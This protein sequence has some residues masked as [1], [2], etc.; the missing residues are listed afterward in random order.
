LVDN[1]NEKLEKKQKKQKEVLNF[2]Y[3]IWFDRIPQDITD[4]VIRSINSNSELK[5][6]Y[7]LQ[8]DIDLENASLGFESLLWDESLSQEQ[9]LS[10]IKLFNKMITWDEKYPVFID[11]AWILFFQSVEDFENHKPAWTLFDISQF[12]NTRIWGNP[13]HT[14]MENLRKV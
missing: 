8:K 13:V 4:I 5:S 10:F 11:R 7:W 12:I 14:I 2:L 3:E 6:K 9:K 1:L